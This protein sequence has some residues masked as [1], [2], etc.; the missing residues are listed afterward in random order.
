[1]FQNDKFAAILGKTNL[2]ESGLLQRFLICNTEAEPQELPTQDYSISPEI[3]A[4]WGSRIREL[5]ETYRLRTEAT[6]I[7]PTP[8]AKELFR[9]FTNEI[10]RRRRKGGDLRD[11]QTY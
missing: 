10:V 9:E 6:T 3:F 5:I 11:I 4:Q 8:E 2:T 1:M 7:R